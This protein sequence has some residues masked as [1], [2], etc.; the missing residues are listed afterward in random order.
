[1]KLY[2]T[3]R[4]TWAGT[5]K[6]WKDAMKAEGSDPKTAERKLVEVPTSKPELMEF[7]TFHNV[8]PLNPRGAH[9]PEPAGS[10]AIPTE[11]PP[12][13]ALPAGTDID[14]INPDAFFNALHLTTRLRLAVTA[15]DDADKVVRASNNIA[16]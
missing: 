3:P 6:D 12:A 13:A 10:V 11:E 16:K 14:A 8:N 2:C 15:I 7:L 4:G 5:E 1:M 9:A